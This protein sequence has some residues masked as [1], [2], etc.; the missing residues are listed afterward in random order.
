MPVIGIGE[1]G[2]AALKPFKT[3][4]PPPR[5]TLSDS[6]AADP[7]RKRNEYD[8]F[9]V[10]LQGN[11]VS[12]GNTRMTGAQ[13]PHQT[14]TVERGQHLLIF[15]PPGV[16]GRYL[17]LDTNRGRLQFGTDG[18]THGHNALGATNAFTIAQLDFGQF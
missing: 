17:H 10:D 5:H 14:V 2:K 11:V 8:L 18:S 7:N 9:V 1:P 4:S 13:D 12:S 6:T 15:Q 3:G 16:D